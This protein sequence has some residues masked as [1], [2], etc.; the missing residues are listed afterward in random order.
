MPRLGDT[1]YS[2]AP[3]FELRTPKQDHE[4]QEEGRRGEDIISK[5]L[6]GGYSYEDHVIEVLNI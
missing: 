2:A 5:F 1:Q 6:T 3:N 4:R